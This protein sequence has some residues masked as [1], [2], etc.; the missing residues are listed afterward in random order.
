MTK[1][2]TDCSEFFK[3]DNRVLWEFLRWLA[4]S[5]W[6]NQRRNK[7]VFSC[8]GTAGKEKKVFKIRWN[9]AEEHQKWG[10]RVMKTRRSLST[11]TKSWTFIFLQWGDWLGKKQ[12]NDDLSKLKQLSNYLIWCGER[13]IR[14]CMCVCVCVCVCVCERERGGGGGRGRWE[15]RR[16][17]LR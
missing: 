9:N 8:E 17:G 3:V 5:P 13:F 15:N 16:T 1:T 4:N 7:K 11:V 6:S 2:T 14:A 12:N 10:L